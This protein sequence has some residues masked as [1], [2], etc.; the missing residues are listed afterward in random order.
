MDLNWSIVKKRG[1]TVIEGVGSGT[2]GQVFSAQHPRIGVIVAIKC[3]R[4]NPADFRMCLSV[5]REISIL[6]QLSTLTPCTFTTRLFDVFMDSKDVGSASFIYVVTEFVECD[7]EKILCF[8]P[9]V[10][11]FSDETITVLLYNSLCAL[12]YLH[13][14]KLIHR[15]IKPANILINSECSIYITDFGLARKL[16]KNR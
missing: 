12:K 11:D 1:Y 8:N 7:L 15:D 5:L 2:F 14:A 9:K 4:I 3:I 16:E 6:R 13:S 10:E